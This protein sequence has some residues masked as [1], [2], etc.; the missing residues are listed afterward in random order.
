MLR[1]GFD[2]GGWR[3][4]Q[5]S[6][7][8]VAAARVSGLSSCAKTVLGAIR[9][10]LAERTENDFGKTEEEV[11]RYWCER[12]GIPWLGRADRALYE[13]KRAGRNTVVGS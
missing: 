12:S 13:A 5:T 4:E 10:R 6:E 11:A 3:Y 2:F 1:L 8:R 9:R 7:L